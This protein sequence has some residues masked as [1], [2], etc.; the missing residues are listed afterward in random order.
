MKELKQKAL[1]LMEANQK[2]VVYATSDGCF[3]FTFKE[4]YNWKTKQR[5]E[6]LTFSKEQIESEAEVIEESTKRS[7][8][9]KK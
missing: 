6:M 1:D 4:A 5:L 3:F 8:K 2:D 7:T 9:T